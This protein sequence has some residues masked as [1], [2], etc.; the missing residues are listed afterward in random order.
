[1]SDHATDVVTRMLAHQEGVE[2]L[3]GPLH[4]AIQ[5]DLFERCVLS[6][7]TT[8]DQQAP[9]LVEAEMPFGV[10][11]ENWRTLP[12]AVSKPFAAI[13][14]ATL[15]QRI[16]AVSE[17]PRPGW[18]PDAGIVWCHPLDVVPDLPLREGFKLVTSSDVAVQEALLLPFVIGTGDLS[19]SLTSQWA[20]KRVTLTARLCS[21]LSL[22]RGAY[23]VPA[24]W[25]FG[26]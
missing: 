1:M 4:N 23:R 26:G 19:V 18:L 11:P 8:V 15:Y 7:A 10:T 9:V 13:V 5:H 14:N 2:Q 12:W 16:A 25:M 24:S 6:R 3:L 21:R 22:T 17:Y 20:P